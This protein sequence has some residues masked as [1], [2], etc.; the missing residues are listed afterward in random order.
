MKFFHY[1]AFAV[2]LTFCI[3]TTVNAKGVSPYLPLKL[4][5][6]IEL[7]IERVV[8]I[9]QM[10]SLS[11][12][13]HIATVYQYLKKL[14]NSHPIL[15]SR[16]NNYIKRYKKQSGLTHRKIELAHSND[17]GDQ[18]NNRGIA[19][20]VNFSSTFSAFYQFN[21]Y[22]I[23]NAGG[24]LNKESKFIPHQSYISLGYEYLQ[25]DIG[26]REHWLSPMQV[27]AALLSTNAEPIPSITLSNV[28]PISPWNVKYDF[29]LGQLDKMDGILFN[30]QRTSGKPLLL[31]MHLSIQPFDWWVIGANRT[32]QF[33]GGERGAGF[34][35]IW[36]AIIDPVN[37]DNCGSGE[38]DC[39]NS[40]QEVGNQI[41]SI[42]TRFDLD[43]Y[44]FPLSI[45]YEYA[46]EDTKGHKN[47]QLGNLAY[48]LGLFLPYITESTSLYFEYSDFHTHWYEHHI[49]G[50]GYRNNG[51]GMGHWWAGNRNNGDLAGA[52]ASTIRL[53]T[54]IDST[55]HLEV[56]LKSVEITEELAQV[57]YQR[58]NEIQIS[59]QH[60][61]E[62]G[63]IG[64]TLN[65]G[66]DTYGDSYY[67][68]AVNY[69]W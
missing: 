64:L 68:A 62:T 11:K 47:Y 61:Y 65:V 14:E 17:E 2:T 46:G 28:K 25:V 34:G 41:A 55:N 5:N 49:Y 67:R 59:L 9:S 51:T 1:A 36:K 7:E 69:T 60:V 40:D 22:F 63:F 39:A 27:S 43:F 23:A 21:E 8:S 32:F 33:S 52:I 54:D 38:T 45:Y 26:Y 29:S 30:G 35:D 13:Y 16:V 20:D 44:D 19:Q 12:P 18:M 31:S 42:T 37:S 66:R 15:Y 50:E 48:S 3:T 4:D 56:M 6:L 10:P 58:M 57:D 53:N 24:T